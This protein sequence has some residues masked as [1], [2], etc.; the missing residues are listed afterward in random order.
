MF[1]QMVR[2]GIA[3]VSHWRHMSY[4][5]LRNLATEVGLIGSHRDYTRFIILG[6]SRSGSNFLRGLLNA[7]PQIVAF[8]E[9]FQTPDEIAWGLTGYGQS[10]YLRTL[11]REDPVRFLESQ[12][13][14]RFPRSVAAVGFKIFYYHAQHD[15]WRPV[16][17]YLAEQ[18][19][20]KVIH[21][22]RENILRTHL[23]RKRA[24]LTD[25]WVNV[26]GEPMTQPPVTL[27]Y[28]ECLEDFVTTRA[29]ELRYDELFA[30]HPKITVRY[31]D[32]DTDYAGEMA[33]VQE[34]LGVSPQPVRPETYKQSNQPL[35]Q[36]IANYAELR[37]RFQGTEW[38]SFF[39]E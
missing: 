37:A 18:K 39:E 3:Q 22:R 19:D 20:L 14:R 5:M 10:R 29:W 23:S 13:Y 7:H 24:M 21:I 9:I 17:R 12:V 8:G 38:E 27:D 32:L 33:R 16:W 36:A 6:R 25:T 34:F 2:R 28:R 26:T 15:G 4:P 31:E 1:R 35:S 30:D 11:H